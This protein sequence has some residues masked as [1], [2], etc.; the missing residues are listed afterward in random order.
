MQFLDQLFYFIITLGVLVLVHELGHF[1]AAKA[2]G[3]RVD[4][5]SIGF[6]P[7]AFGRKFGETDYCISWIPIG[8]YVKI[9]G[10]IDE[11]MD[12]E[13]LARSPEP[14][15]FR[16]KPLWQRMLVICAG[17][18][19]N[20]FLAIGI[21]WGINYVQGRVVWE[22]TEVGYVSAADSLTDGHGLEPGD[23]I[24]RVNG[25]PVAHWDD[26]RSVVLLKS[27]GRDVVFDVMRN[28]SEHHVTVPHS[29]VADPSTGLLTFFPNDIDVV[30]SV[31]SP[32]KPAD[33]AGLKPLDV[34]VA[35]ND[36]PI[37]AHTEVRSL[38]REN[39]GRDIMIDWKRDGKPM[40]AAVTVPT[41]DSL[42]GI[43][44]SPRF[45]GRTTRISYSLLEALPVGFGNMVSMSELFVQQLWML[46]T[47]KVRFTDS[48][49]GPVAIAK[50]ASESAE[51]GAISFFG[52]MGLLS[53]TLAIMN[54]LPVPALDG[55]HMVFL[56]YEAI[57]RREIPVKIRMILQQA[58]FVLLLAFM[59]F[60]FVNDIIKLY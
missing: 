45:A 4:R 3:M 54:L 42:I 7:R 29:A 24:L 28:G 19:M 47:G 51:G 23:R 32:G 8:G 53:L 44:Y 15:E 50:M 35:I 17:V 40:R 59:A 52:F 1:L 20:I 57:F 2:C 25:E 34:L 39:V 60:V 12:T 41:S 11:R 22:T 27:L 31:V 16:S 5:F 38:V 9:A 37:H 46:V 48:V 56:V 14:W 18:I 6:P 58:G 13:H 49:G 43:Q 10:M 36:T 33:K 21:F 55:G 30:V 26:I